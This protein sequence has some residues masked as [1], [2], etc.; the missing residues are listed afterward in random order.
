MNPWPD[1]WFDLFWSAYPRRVAKKAAFR[2][3]QAV[4]KNNEVEWERFLNSV[5][6]F[7]RSVRGKDMQ[8]VPHPATWIN[9]GRWDDEIAEA[10]P[11]N[12]FTWKATR[13]TYVS[14]YQ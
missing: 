4:R 2:A 1:N 10:T 13:G 3:L 12:D 14:K 8:Y 7:A 11:I 5:Q 9:G 6:I